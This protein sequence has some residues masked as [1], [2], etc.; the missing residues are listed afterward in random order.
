MKN[1]RALTP[2]MIT[3]L[4]VSF[5]VAVG[6]V[7]INLGRAEVEEKAECTLEI[8]LKLSEVGGEEQFCLDRAKE[9]LFFT[10]ENGVNI[11]VEGL[12]MNVIGTKKAESYELGEAKME[13]AGVFLK[14]VPYSL[15]EM[16]EIKQVK[17]IPKVNLFDKELICQ[18]QGLVVEKVRDC[19]GLVAENL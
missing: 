18:E 5:A 2:L 4:L 17:V 14:Y 13:K 19:K 12:V 15:E 1:K 3:F 9:Q 7:V 8:G 10:V 6:V 16:G 11:K